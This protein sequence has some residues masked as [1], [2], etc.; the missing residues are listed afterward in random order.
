MVAI[1]R[2]PGEKLVLQ[3]ANPNDETC[4][5]N[6]GHHASIDLPSDNDQFLKILDTT[7]A[8]NK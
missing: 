4:L 8:L 1:W 3:A 5:I 7:F 2:E 6:G